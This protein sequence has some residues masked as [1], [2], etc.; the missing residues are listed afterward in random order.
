MLC[1][2]HFGISFM[3]CN[4]FTAFQNLVAC[5]TEE[6]KA[7][8]QPEQEVFQD[9]SGRTWDRCTVTG[10]FLPEVDHWSGER[11]V[12]LSPARQLHVQTMLCAHGGDCILHPLQSE[13]HQCDQQIDSIESGGQ[14]S[15]GEI[16]TAKFCILFDVITGHALFSSEM[17]N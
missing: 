8:G 10:L 15:H 9:G 1:V 13:S 3:V 11:S 5:S 14:I 16:R 4:P 12:A 17:T 7:P 6:Y 2:Y